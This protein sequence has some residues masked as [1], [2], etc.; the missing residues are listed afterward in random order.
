M[1]TTDE[2]PASAD[3]RAP[4]TGRMLAAGGIA[5]FAVNGI[6]VGL[7]CATP[8]VALS[9]TVGRKAALEMLLTA[10]A[11]PSASSRTGRY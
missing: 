9:R 4:L 11:P 5:G 2:Q 3:G 7:F 10:T 6:N 1:G 8:M